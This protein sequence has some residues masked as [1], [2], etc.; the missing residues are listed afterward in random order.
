[1]ERKFYIE[2]VSQHKNSYA[3]AFA[4]HYAHKHLV[5]YIQRG[6]C[7][8]FISSFSV[9][10]ARH[11]DKIL[12]EAND[13]K[14]THT[15]HIAMF[16]VRVHFIIVTILAIGSRTSTDGVLVVLFSALHSPSNSF[17]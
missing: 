8:H 3:K 1:M 15:P 7:A 9:P 2:I 5:C 10:F 12:F 13:S 16:G 14:G 6:H 17:Q 11:F 4:F